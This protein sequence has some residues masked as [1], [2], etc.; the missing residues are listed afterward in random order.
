MRSATVIHLWSAGMERYLGNIML[1]HS[2]CYIS[3]DELKDIFFAIPA[4]PKVKY[5]TFEHVKDYHP[6]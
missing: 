5:V 2:I 3:E 1:N 4:K 6:N